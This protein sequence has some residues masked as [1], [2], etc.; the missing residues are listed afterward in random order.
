MNKLKKIIKW[1]LVLL[2][3]FIAGVI[4]QT[5][6]HKP[7]PVQVIETVSQA[8]IRSNLDIKPELSGNA[9][10]KYHDLV[11]EYTNYITKEENKNIGL[12]DYISIKKDQ[13]VQ[14]G[15]YSEKDL[16]VDEEIKRWLS[17]YNTTKNNGDIETN[18][19]SINGTI[20][21]PYKERTNCYIMVGV[22]TIPLY[23]ERTPSTPKLSLSPEPPLA[24]TFIN[25]CSGGNFSIDFTLSNLKDKE[26]IPVYLAA[27]AFYEFLGS[28]TIPFAIGTD[29]NV[30]GLPPSLLVKRKHNPPVK[31]HL[32]EIDKKELN[33]VNITI[34][35]QKGLFVSPYG[36]DSLAKL[37]PEF[38]LYRTTVSS[39]DDI[40]RLKKLPY[41]S[42]LYIQIFD[43]ATEN[44]IKMIVPSSS[45]KINIEIPNKVFKIRSHYS[46]PAIV[47]LPPSNIDDGEFVL[48]SIK[49]L[50]NK[51]KFKFDNTDPLPLVADDLDDQE[52]LIE[53]KSGNKSLGITSIHPKKGEISIL[54]PIPKKIEKMIGQISLFGKDRTER[55]LCSNC[56]V[57]IKYTDKNIVTSGSGRFKMDNINILD[58]QIE[59]II[60]DDYQKFLVPLVIQNN[61][62][63]LNL[64]LELPSKNV[65]NRWK[66]MEP[67]LPINGMIYGNF[68]YHKS[69]KAFISGIDKNIVRE[70]LYFDDV[71]ASPVKSKYATSSSKE[72]FGFSKFL[73]TNVQAGEYVLYILTGTEIIHSRIIKIEPGAVTIIY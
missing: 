70:A 34:S 8:R 9:K 38:S 7:E 20:Y 35:A 27:Y 47:I 19:Y 52:T 3:P 1:L 69:Y 57:E 41:G 58:N 48:S 31:I 37:A 13:L 39:Q 17:S 4:F 32:Q 10:Q 43:P 40:A 26:T 61:L 59:L 63:I 21:S 11:L 25:N 64:G 66:R 24:Y 14:E 16:V 6:I 28:Y 29:S 49:S 50:K 36:L 56:Q 15:K 54:N 18:R 46:N 2:V 33:N 45:E 22:Y 67:T 71:N 72:S 12:K 73:F 42:N 60:E 5:F 44:K 53:L 23:K 55:S 30:N 62:N 68:I 51:S 65:L